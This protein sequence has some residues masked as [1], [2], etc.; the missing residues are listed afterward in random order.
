[1]PPLTSIYLILAAME[2]N[3]SEYAQLFNQIKEKIRTSRYAAMK[4]VNNELIDL[5]WTIGQAIV[6]RQEQFKWGKSVVEQ[7][8]SDLQ[9][10]Y[11]DSRGYSTSNLW[12]MRN[13]YREYKMKEKLAP[14]VREIGWSHNIAI[15]EKCKDDLEREYYIIMTKKFGW[16]KNILI[17]QIE[18]N[19]YERSLLN[20]TNFDTTLDQKYQSHAALAVKDSYLFDFLEISTDFSEREMELSLIMNIRKFLLEMGGDFAL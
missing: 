19:N 18:S 2:I 4:T 13:F 10:A 9:R 5:Y 11:P 7:L 15:V 12:R 8:S 6:E 1:M 20:Q 16:T 17:H 14:M 3:S